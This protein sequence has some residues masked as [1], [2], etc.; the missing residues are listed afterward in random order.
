VTSRRPTPRL[1][2]PR[3]TTGLAFAV[4]DR[5]GLREPAAA[6]L[7][8]VT[9]RLGARLVSADRAFAEALGADHRDLVDAPDQLLATS[10]G[11]R[12]EQELS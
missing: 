12:C 5:H 11:S 10:P 3:P 7:A 4:G 6:L 2:P 8:A 9:R 1:A